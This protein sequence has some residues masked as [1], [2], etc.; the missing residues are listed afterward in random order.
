[1]AKTTTVHSGPGSSRTPTLAIALLVATAL[2]L[3]ADRPLVIDLATPVEHGMLEVEAGF[4]H[5][6]DDH[7]HYYVPANLGLGVLPNLE[8]AMG[9]F[10]QAAEQLVTEDGRTIDDVSVGDLTLGGKWRFLTAERAWA[11]QAL[12]LTVKLPTAERD[13]GSGHEDYDLAWIVSKS[14]GEKVSVHANVAYT[15]QT[16]GY[17]DLVRY[18]MAAD[19]QSGSRWQWVLEAYAITV[20]EQRAETSVI[21]NGGVRFFARD[22]LVFD[23]ALGA[24]V[25][26]GPDFLATVGLTWTFRVFPGM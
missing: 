21:V 26:D 6:K 2:P 11:D 19:Y 14:I 13:W 1:M 9:V 12:A 8:L 23:A 7:R 24:G 20:L 15:W 10:G 22:N 4:G 18:G 16:G 3:Q 17:D 25:A 5:I